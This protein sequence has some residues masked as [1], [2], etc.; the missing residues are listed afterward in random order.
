MDPDQFIHV[1]GALTTIKHLRVHPHRA[2]ELVNG[3]VS[4][5]IDNTKE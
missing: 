2:A 3:I 5:H 1:M 4:S